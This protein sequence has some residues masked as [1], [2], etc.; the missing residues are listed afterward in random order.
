[1]QNT[2]LIEV[3]PDKGNIK[4]IVSQYSST[5]ETFIPIIHNLARLKLQMGHVI[6][7]CSTLSECA[8]LYVIFQTQLGSDFLYPTDAPNLSK[9]RLVDMF[10]LC[11]ELGVKNQILESFTSP[12]STFRVVIATVA[13]GLGIDCPD[14]VKL[15]TWAH[16]RMLKPI[17]K[18]QAVQDEMA[19]LLKPSYSKRNLTTHWIGP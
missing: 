19:T 4:Y 10:T 2:E 3:S 12:N 14:I 15:S 17:C 13:F 16:L 9:F 11:T 5:N 1:M 8:S 18:Q 6:I 7:F